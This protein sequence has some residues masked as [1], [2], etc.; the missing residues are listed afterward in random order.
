MINRFSLLIFFLIPFITYAQGD[1]KIIS[2]SRQSILL[3]YTPVYSDT[4][5]IHVDNKDFIKVGIPGG[6]IPDLRNFGNPAVP[7]KIINLGVPGEY[8][9]TIEIVSSQSKKISGQII[10]IS[11]PENDSAGLAV[12]YA[13]GND[14]FNYK[15]ATELVTFGQYGLMRS[16]PIQSIIISPIKFY[17]G[18][19]QIV[20]YTKIIFKI[21]YSTRQ[22][23]AKQPAGDFLNGILLNYD[24]AKYWIKR[25]ERN[26]LSKLK[27][28]QGTVLMSGTWGRFETPAEGIY[29][30]TRSMLAGLGINPDSVDP[31][32]I[33]IYNNG[34]KE[35]PENV[36]ASRPTDLVE[37]AVLF[38]GSN[39]KH[40]SDGDY[41][42]LY[43]RGD[44]F[45]TYDSSTG[46]ISRNHND[47]S[48]HNYYWITSGGSKGKRIQQQTG[49]KLQS[50]YNQTTSAGFA[51]W[52][53]DKINI[54]KSGREYFGDA[55]S[56][57]SPSMTY[58]NKLPGRINGSTINYK[59]YFADASPDPFDL[60]IEENSTSIFNST[61][62]GYGKTEYVIGIG[63]S[64]TASYRGNLTSDNR[65]QLK[66]T[67]SPYT[68]A[69][70][71]YLDYF[72]IR[73]QKNL[74]ADANNLMF[75]SKDT[76]SVIQY[77]MTG[78]SSSD[79]RVFNISDFSNVKLV[80]NL[81][82][83]LGSCSFQS[84]ERKGHVEKYYAVEGSG[85]MTPANLTKMS[86][87]VSEDLL[88]PNTGAK[89]IIITTSKF[90]DAAE[91]LK[92][93]KENSAKEKI[94]TEIVYVEDIY[95]EFSC[96]SLDP[97]A[98]RDFI[99]YAYVNWQT[100]PEYVLLFGKG[101]YDPKNLEGYNTDFV[102][103]Y[104]TT[105]SLSEIDSYPTDDYFVRVSGNDP[106]TDLAYGRI[107]AMN[108]EQA[109][110]IVKKIIQYDTGSNQGAW[111]NLITLVADD[112]WHG[113][114]YEG[115][116]HTV[117]SEYLATYCI[118]SSFDLN[119]IYLAAYP[120]EITS[121]GRRIPEVNKAIINS[122]N[123]GTSILN[124]I[125]HGSPDLWAD[126]QVFVQSTTIP[127]LHNPDYFF[128]TAATC[129]FGRYD[130][131]N[132]Q[133][134]TENLL[135]LQNGGCIAGFSSSRLA[136]S[137]Q[138]NNLIDQF[139]RI[140]FSAARDTDNLPFSLGKITLKT[141]Q[142]YNDTNSQKY[143][144]F[145]DPTVRLS[146]PEYNASIDSIDNKSLANSVQI[147]AL[148]DVKIN[149]EVK[150]GKGAF[151][152]GYS[153]TG[154]L[155]VYDS[156]RQ[157]LLS[158]LGNY[159][160]T[161]S[162]GLI[163]RG[164]VSIVNGK[165]NANFVV[166]KDISYENKSGKIVMYFYNSNTDGIAYT[167]NITVGGTDSSAV[168][169]KIGPDIN[170]FFD[171]TTYKNTSLVN[172]NSILIVKLYDGNGL[173]T[174]GTGI[175][176]KL[177]GVLNDD[178]NNPIDFSNFFTGDLNAG[179]KSGEINYRF[180]NLEPGNYKL[181]VT[182]WDVFNNFSSKTINFT[183]VDNEGLTIKNVY[184]YPDPFRYNT[185]FTFQQNVS[186]P[187]NVKIRIFTVA[188][189]LIR[190]IEK[191]GINE[192]FVKVNWD[193]RDQDGDIIANGT[194]LYKVIVQTSDGEYNKSV[195]GK[196]AIIR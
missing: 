33:K 54:G 175:G 129:D 117:A 104:Q 47:Y 111:R 17:P 93:F 108:D 13:V 63:R 69:S 190:Q 85:Y 37:N 193:G 164:R 65:S 187:I 50:P 18:E 136:Y 102:P 3:E 80:T 171:D 169:N 71:G 48:N 77:N 134:S 27:S 5:T 133:C 32:T 145:G 135:F 124:F 166:P 159:P 152:S 44:D 161:I 94:S 8:G 90:K 40:F 58:V 182:A 122:I 127:Q 45:W 101:T 125:G 25:P 196:L 12:K 168:N 88:A 23:I 156:Q 78:F 16:I 31:S 121:V 67:I 189:R 98:V 173:N 82:V 22:T 61:L 56:Q 62:Y 2:S 68:A 43:G 167:T 142:T 9:N 184:N 112:G 55:F 119:K 6:M 84:S 79:I 75:F 106:L 74:E 157:L 7:E 97:T 29:K 95:N 141:K 120:V 57:N 86:N 118:P 150:N 170:I 158:A 34:G 24:V 73:Y 42:L 174:T 100:T 70:K 64:I 19:N 140:M 105:E 60:K 195:L 110:D 81:S 130:E 103:T 92:S 41:I 154:V 138:N 146:F 114:T 26:G 20:F 59:I 188:G 15:P 153:G 194:Y 91:T 35:L 123:D 116:Y 148:S 113:N 99:R 176:H 179:G 143:E 151:W 177:E 107:P 147:K 172:P 155:S 4:T 21:N 14:Y 163:F 28:T 115:N 137:A 46:I 144:I 49:L 36:N 83:N 10:P 183:V 165:F 149:G 38:V 39:D 11:N 181:K 191:L 87:P 162:G 192:K 72:E 126:E 185:T 139:Y 66:F 1:I 52:D 128:L 89:F 51:Q 30:I 109:N 178:I 53:E 132:Y 76:T 131:T 96:G 160:M 186:K 180:T